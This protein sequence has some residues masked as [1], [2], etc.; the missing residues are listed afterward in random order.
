M[1]S[2]K[3]IG[4]S[5]LRQECEEKFA[6]REQSATNEGPEHFNCG[7]K[8]SDKHDDGVCTDRTKDKV[9]SGLR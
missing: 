8:D 9:K 4:K 1:I 6:S 2:G 5:R 7:N 3:L